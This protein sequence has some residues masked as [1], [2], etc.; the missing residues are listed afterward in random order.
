MYPKLKVLL[1]ILYSIRYGAHHNLNPYF[2]D[3]ESKKFI[4][5][6]FLKIIKD[7]NHEET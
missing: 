2:I 4:M 7:N 3:G 1:Y 5:N 6:N